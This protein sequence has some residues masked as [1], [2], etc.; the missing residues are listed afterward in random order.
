MKNKYNITEVN[1][2]ISNN[3]YSCTIPDVIGIVFVILKLTGLINW[4]W[5]Q[6]LS[7][8]WISTIIILLVLGIGYL[9]M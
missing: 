1:T 2:E 5:L 4:S 6:V 3:K 7:P 8:W 9:F